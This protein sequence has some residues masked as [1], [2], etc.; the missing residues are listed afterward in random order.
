[1]SKHK[2]L[3]FLNQKS[4]DCVFVEKKV[5]ETSASKAVSRKL[6]MACVHQHCSAVLRKNTVC[7]ILN[8]IDTLI[9]RPIS[10]QSTIMVIYC[11]YIMF[12]IVDNPF[13]DRRALIGFNFFRNLSM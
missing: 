2:Y 9:L 7:E 13:S 6:Q 1:M 3:G 12:H 10:G 5:N 11:M 8:M 4:R